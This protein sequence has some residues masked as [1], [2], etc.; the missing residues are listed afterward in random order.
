MR[1]LWKVKRKCNYYSGV[2]NEIGTDYNGDI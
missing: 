2:V 1:S